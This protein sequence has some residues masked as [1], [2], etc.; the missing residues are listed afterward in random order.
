MGAGFNRVTGRA[1][2]TDRIAAG[3]CDA[4]LHAR[5]ITIEV[6]EEIDEA[7]VAVGGV[8]GDAALLA[9]MHLDDAA[10]LGREDR[11]A[12]RAGMSIAQWRRE[13]SPRKCVK[14]LRKSSTGTFGMGSNSARS[15]THRSPTAPAPSGGRKRLFW[16][17]WWSVP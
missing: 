12:A 10:F 14:L 13:P 5:V 9:R 2:E 15:A 16:V 8:E 1:H 6:S 7:L 3:N 17:S 11:C 4:F